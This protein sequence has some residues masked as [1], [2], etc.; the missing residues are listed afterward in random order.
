MD[1]SPPFRS[2]TGP[3]LMSREEEM[4]RLVLRALRAVLPGARRPRHPRR[5]TYA[6]IACIAMA[7]VGSVVAY[8]QI[9]GT[10]NAGHLTAFG[11]I[12]GTTGFPSWY[13]DDTGKRLEPCLDP[14]N[15]LCGFVP[16]DVPDPQSPVSMPDN[17]PEE[18]FYMLAGNTMDLPGGGRAATTLSLEGAFQNGGPVAGDQ[19]TFGRVRF[20][21]DGLRAG[22]KYTITHPYGQDTFVAEQDPGAAA[23]VGRIRF[24]EDTGVSPGQFGGALNSRIG[25]FLKWDATAP[26]APAGYIGDPDINHT[27]TG[28]PYNTNCVRLERPAV[29]SPTNQS[30]PLPAGLDAADCAQSSTFSLQGKLATTGG[31]D[32]D[33]A[34]YTRDATGGTL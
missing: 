5:V 20:F 30:N 2:G 22:Q 19:I 28:S 18:V 26:A 27:V 29:G 14:T 4:T 17:F 16:G 23:G 13:K 15:S 11:P 21:F 3:L 34:V 12:S 7:S 8:G 10:A 33:R 6:L 31:V 25:P 24:T 9:V 1:S 32:V